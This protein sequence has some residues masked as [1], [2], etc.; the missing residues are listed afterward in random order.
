M[1]EAVRTE[2]VGAVLV[3]TLD[4]P[5]ANAI[6]VPTSR[7]LYDAFARLESDDALRVG[8][9]TGAG[10]R[11]FSAGWDLKAAVAGEA[12]DAD[13]GPGGFAG[14]TELFGRSKPVIAAVNGLALGG[15][16]ELALAADLMVVAEHA[17]LA[18][19]EVRVGVVADSGGLLRLPRRLP[20][21]VAREMLLTGRR[22]GADEAV[23]WGLASRRVPAADLMDASLELA[24][25]II[26]G[27]PLAVAAIQEALAATAG[28]HVRDG[29]ALMRSGELAAYA[30][31]L[32]SEDAVEGPRAFAEKR[33]PH[34]RGR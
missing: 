30:R 8:I 22:M 18:L 13:H 11:F 32:R 9:V 19:P 12:V 4:R 6:D 1:V 21:A 5:T 34:W 26:A 20:E 3:V 14:L 10:E 7:A 25:E 16:L 31:M 28:L 24:G 27:A 29:F 23:R 2:I 33:A 17:E 15:G